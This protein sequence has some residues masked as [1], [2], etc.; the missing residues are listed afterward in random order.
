MRRLLYTGWRLRLRIKPAFTSPVVVPFS[1]PLPPLLGL[2]LHLLL[3]SA[4]S[5]EFCLLCC[6]PEPSLNFFNTARRGPRESA[7]PREFAHW[8]AKTGQAQLA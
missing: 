7:P 1:S 5:V 4:S 2:G 6:Q 3:P 8:G